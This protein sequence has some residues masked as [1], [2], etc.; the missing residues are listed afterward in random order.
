MLFRSPYYFNHDMWLNILGVTVVPL[1][2]Q[3][4]Q[5]GVPDVAEAAQK[6]TARTRAIV[7]VSPNNPTGAIYPPDIL[8]QFFDLARDRHI[9]LVLDETYKD[10]LP[11]DGAPHTLLGAP[12][13]SGTLIQ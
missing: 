8:R 2:F 7:L 3:A 12:G 9:A 13:R 10:F 4:A 5:G 6:I 11:A 1:S